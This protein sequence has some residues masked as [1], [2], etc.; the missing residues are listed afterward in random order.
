MQFMVYAIPVLVSIL[1][2]F[3]GF[4]KYMGNWSREDIEKIYPYFEATKLEEKHWEYAQKLFG[5][6][7]CICGGLNIVT[8]LLLIPITI[9]MVRGYEAGQID[10]FVLLLY[11]L[12]PSLIYMTASRVILQVK[13]KQM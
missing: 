12:V 3:N 4:I 2:L 1:L 8:T 5:K 13:L 7:L 10:R 6:L 11:A 9:K